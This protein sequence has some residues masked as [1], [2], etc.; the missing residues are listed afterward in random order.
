M[1]ESILAPDAVIAEDCPGAPCTAGIMPKTFGEQ[2]SA[3]Q[4]ETLVEFLS[5][6]GGSGGEAGSTSE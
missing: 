3:A 2:L 5:S 4:L 1:R 6:L